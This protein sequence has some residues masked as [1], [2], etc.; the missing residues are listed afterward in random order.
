MT[1]K[2]LELAEPSQKPEIVTIEARGKQYTFRELE[3]GEYDKL[4]KAATHEEADEDGIMQDVTDSTLL[5]RLM[6]PKS[7]VDPILTPEAV[8]TMG[9]R[10]YRALARIVNELHYGDEPVKRIKDDET[11]AE[12]TPKGNG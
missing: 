10:L 6:V 9:A 5:L 7:C 11:P 12:E 3:I 8:A 1:T 2:S 4:V